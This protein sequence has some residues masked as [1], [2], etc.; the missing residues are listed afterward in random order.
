MTERCSITLTLLM[1]QELTAAGLVNISPGRSSGCVF[2]NTQVISA[3]AEKLAFTSNMPGD[4]PEPR[5]LWLPT[6]HLEKAVLLVTGVNADDHSSALLDLLLTR[7]FLA[8][9]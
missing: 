4:S 6:V 7:A 1:Q 2:G 5:K 9:P 8:S 3:S